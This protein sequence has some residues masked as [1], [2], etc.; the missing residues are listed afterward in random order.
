MIRSIAPFH[1]LL[2]PFPFLL[3]PPAVSLAPLLTTLL[4]FFLLL[5]TLSL[6]VEVDDEEDVDEAE[7]AN[8]DVF[9]P[10]KEATDD[11]EIF[12]LATLICDNLVSTAERKIF[13]LSL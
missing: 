3:L 6:P 10:N 13:L 4:T 7:R 5:A 12:A 9:A 1:L 2:L 11:C 8:N